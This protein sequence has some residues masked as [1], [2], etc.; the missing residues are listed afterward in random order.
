MKVCQHKIA[1]NT[2][3][4][5]IFRTISNVD[6]TRPE[7]DSE[8]GSHVSCE[9]ENELD[10]SPQSDESEPAMSPFDASNSNTPTEQPHSN[11]SSIS[12]AVKKRKRRTDTN[13]DV[14]ETTLKQMQE[15]SAERHEQIRKLTETTKPLTELQTWCGALA[16]T[17]EK[18]PAIDQI[19]MKMAISNLVGK[20]ELEIL[21]RMDT[22]MS[23]ELASTSPIEFTP[24]SRT[25][26]MSISPVPPYPYQ[27]Q[28]DS[29]ELQYTNL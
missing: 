1:L 21:K 9:T 8:S 11:C 23:H 16:L 24:M 13:A 4:F 22:G 5:S 19:E 29:T 6:E 17:L 26:S 28:Y 25:V 14:F 12:E 10:F 7:S 15:R 20:K 18:M 27:Y 3:Q 2:I